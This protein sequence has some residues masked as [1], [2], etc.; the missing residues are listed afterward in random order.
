MHSFHLN[1]ILLLFIVL[2]T[3]SCQKGPGA[4]AGPGGVPSAQNIRNTVA[5]RF[6]FTPNQPFS[7]TYIC[8]RRNSNLI[9][10]FQ[11]SSNRNMRVL[12]TTDTYDDYAFDGTYSYQ[13][14]ELRLM[15]PGGPT[16]PFPQGLDETS[17]V[18]MPQ[19]GLIGGFATD[20]MICIC[21]GHDYNVQAPPVNIAHYDC[22]E[23]NIQAATYEDNAVEFVLQSL[24]FG[25]TVNGSIFRHQDTYIAGK[26]T[27]NIRRGYGIYRQDGD[28]F[29]ATF[30]LYRDFVDFAGNRLPFSVQASLPFDDYNLLSGRFI[31][32]DREVVIDQLMPEAGACRLE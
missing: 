5:Q 8:G 22:P 28:Q 24:P 30:S 7:A 32:N 12:F 16:M 21:E 18:I 27:P 29:W 1:F 15:M 31:S 26:T 13:N 6:P 11:F 25:Q 2:A 9:W 14:D 17:R 3:Y 10:H 19:F 23:I 4:Q 20:N